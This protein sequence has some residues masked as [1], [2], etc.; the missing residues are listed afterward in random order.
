MAAVTTRE[1]TSVLR[2]RLQA[3]FCFG[4]ERVRGCWSSVC[5]WQVHV[6]ERWGDRRPSLSFSYSEDAS[7][8][9]FLVITSG[10]TSRSGGYTTRR[11]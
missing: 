1:R 9:G 4:V 2:R 8:G 5:K 3:F 7:N 10:K 11:A 6:N